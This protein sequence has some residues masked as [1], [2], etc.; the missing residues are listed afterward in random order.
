M[1]RTTQYRLLTIILLVAGSAFVW[2]LK[3]I[4]LGLDLQGG[5]HLI[6][7]VETRE[8][9]E[10]E[11]DQVRERIASNLTDQEVAFDQVS[12]T[13]GLEIVVTGVH[14]LQE[15][16]ARDELGKHI[17]LDRKR[18]QRGGASAFDAGLGPQSAPGTHR[19]SGSRGHPEKDRSVRRP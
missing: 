9:M 6:V 11:V 16:T 5:I 19:S 1:N 4:S 17:Q 18:I 7:Q 2:W 3:G 10:A 12:V 13:E 14:A 15:S 8:A